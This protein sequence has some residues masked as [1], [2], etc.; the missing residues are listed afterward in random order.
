MRR[1]MN[2]KRILSRQ[3]GAVAV[4]VALFL[5]VLLGFG[6]L[7]LDISRV[8]VVRNQL[9]NAADAAALA[10]AG[11]LSGPGGATYTKPNWAEA[12]ANALL[13]VKLNGADGS[14]LVEGKVATGY[15]NVTG[16]PALLQPSDITPG[17]FDK[18]AVQVEIS[19]SEGNNGGPLTLFLASVL[20]VPALSLGAS[21]VAAI[22]VPGTVSAGS[23]FPF[24]LTRCAYD[25]YWDSINGKPVKDP[26]TGD[27]QE[28]EI[29]K[30]ENKCFTGQWTTF[31]ININ[32]V[33]GARELI[34]KGNPVGMS[35]GNNTWIQPG[36]KAAL[37]DSVPVPSD[38]LLPVV[39]EL[40][41]TKKGNEPII[42]FA[43]FH[44]TKVVKTGSEKY[45]KGHFI[46]NYKAPGT[47]AGPGG[48][49]PSGAFVPPF[50][51]H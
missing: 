45:V 46:E 16:N 20:G 1:K 48:G 8:F 41:E 29:G 38:V 26:I 43:P 31:D 39:G 30:M 6:A 23:L 2:G 11:A 40:N 15:W 21:A 47:G 42:A 4:L 28:F 12:K 27:P 49:L 25:N 37:Y 17:N 36:T 18:P 51:V 7:A 9:Q 13:A 14:T 50:L 32:S 3:Q 22:S 10:G 19:R 34:A 24:A 44:I 5:V 33:D 35:I